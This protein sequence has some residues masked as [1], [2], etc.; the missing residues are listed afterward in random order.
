[1]HMLTS[2]LIKFG[3]AVFAALPVER[4]LAALLNTWIGKIDAGA[5]TLA[6]ED[7]DYVNAHGTATPDNDR[8]IQTPLPRI[9]NRVRINRPVMARSLIVRLSVR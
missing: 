4:I 7:I 9:R 8:P 3:L 6:V 2:V 5:K 1:M